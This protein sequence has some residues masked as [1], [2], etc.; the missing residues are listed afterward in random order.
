M[1]EAKLLACNMV[2]VYLTN[3]DQFTSYE[4]TLKISGAI[5]VKRTKVFYF[6]W[7]FWIL[8]YWTYDWAG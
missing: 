7:A 1:I 6:F 3:A 5:T 4:A 2:E 8:Q